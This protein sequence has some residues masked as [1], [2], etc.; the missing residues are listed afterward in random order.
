MRDLSGVIAQICEAL[1]LA[2]IPNRQIGDAYD[3]VLCLVPSAD[4]PRAVAALKAQFKLD[5]EAIA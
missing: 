2:A 4:A 5:E 3:A 1:L